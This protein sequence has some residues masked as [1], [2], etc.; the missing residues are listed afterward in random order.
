VTV[1]KINL[2]TVV[3]FL[4]VL[5]SLFAKA[6]GVPVHDNLFGFSSGG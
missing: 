1:K 6:K 2:I 5:A 3:V 4:I